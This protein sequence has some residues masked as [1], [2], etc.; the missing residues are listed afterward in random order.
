MFINFAPQALSV[1]RLFCRPMQSPLARQR[2]SKGMQRHRRRRHGQRSRGI[3]ETGHL[4]DFAINCLAD[5]QNRKPDQLQVA[6]RSPHLSEG[7]IGI[8]VIM[9]H[10]TEPPNH[11][12]ARQIEHHAVNARE[13]G[14]DGDARGI[15]GATRKQEEQHNT[16]QGPV[17]LQQGDCVDGIFQVTAIIAREHPEQ[18]IDDED[19]DQGSPKAFEA[20]NLHGRQIDLLHEI[21]LRDDLAG[22]DHLPREHEAHAKE[23]GRGVAVCGV[24]ALR[25]PDVGHADD[26]HAEDA[27]E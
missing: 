1:G 3:L 16:Q 2:R 25:S 18:R 15:E 19:H 7:R 6:V 20:D 26:R 10:E 11:D 12:G 8:E 22:L 21:L 27:K 4:Q 14:R 24:H 13:M 23:H 5:D 17:V 9:H